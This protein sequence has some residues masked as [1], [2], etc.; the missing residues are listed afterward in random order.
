MF[1]AQGA[2]AGVGAF[3]GGALVALGTAVFALRLFGAP[4]PGARTA[5]AGFFLATVLKWMLVGGG[6]LVLLAWYRLPPGPVLA[7]FC[8]TLAVHLV[9]WRFKV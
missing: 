5:L 8:A 4:A 2:Q 7:G 9:A 1:L 6:L 3:A